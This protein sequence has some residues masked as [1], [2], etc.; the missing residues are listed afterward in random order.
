VDQATQVDQS[1]GR[2]N[3]NE[4]FELNIAERRY[5]QENFKAATAVGTEGRAANLNLQVGV[6]L[7]AGRIDLLLRNVH[8]SVRFRGTLDRILEIINNRQALSPTVP[9]PAAPMPSPE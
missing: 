1:G 3:V 9:A 7:A 4:A 6:A 2:V 5:S 8:G